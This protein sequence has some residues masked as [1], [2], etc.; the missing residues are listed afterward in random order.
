MTGSADLLGGTILYYTKN[1]FIASPQGNRPL[2]MFAYLIKYS[3]QNP[4]VARL[5]HLFAPTVLAFVIFLSCIVGIYT[6]PL[7]LLA[8]FWPAN[9]VMVGILLR[10]PKTRTLAGWVAGVLAFSAADMLTGAA[11]EKALLLNGANLASISAAYLVLRRRPLGVLRLKDRNSI[12]YLLLASVAGGA[13]GGLGGMIANPILF[14]GSAI[15]GGKFWFVTELANYVTVLPL[16]LAATTIGWPDVLRNRPSLA[17]A[18]P[19]AALCLSCLAGLIIG[20]PGAI[21]F[22]VPALLWCGLTYSVFTTALL[23]AVS[24]Y[25]IMS[26]LV[27]VYLPAAAQSPNSFDLVSYRLGVSLLVLSPLVQAVSNASK[28]SAMAELITEAK[29]DPLTQIA[30]RRTFL[31]QAEKFF[32]QESGSAVVFMMD[33]DHFKRIN[34]TCGHSGGDAVLVEFVR[35]V[36]RCL[37]ICDLFGRVGGEEFALLLPG[38]TILHG[39]LIADRIRQAVGGEPVQLDDGRS[40]P[41]TVSIGMAATHGNDLSIQELLKR[42]DRALY[43]AKDAGR[44]RIEVF[45]QPERSRIG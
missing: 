24:G 17:G 2:R 4:E 45:V 8:T 31:A 1:C 30:N 5:K 6:R 22:V 42:A 25:W 39:R 34:D 15:T 16:V 41:V 27:T 43:L 3:S 12:P 37:R 11:P 18:T 20:G 44:D 26:Q 13:A 38:C 33:I 35:R 32:S 9:A 7:G 29:L 23:T 10:W 40:L 28:R 14:D 21:A 36:A 19:F